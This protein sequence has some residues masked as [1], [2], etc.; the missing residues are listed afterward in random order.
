MSEPLCLLAEVPV[1]A[2]RPYAS[3]EYQD[4][5]PVPTPASVYGMLLSLLGVP[6]ERKAEHCGAELALAVER[7]PERSKVFRKLRRGGDLE[8][9]RPD[10]QDVLTDL[11]LWVWVRRGA[12]T[13][14][15]CLADRLRAALANRFADVTRSGGVS[16]GESSYLLNAL[17]EQ[18]PPNEL[19]FVVPDATGFYSLPVWVDH[20]VAANTQ[21]KRFRIDDE[22]RATTDA[23]A[24]AWF[25]IPTPPAE[26]A[27]V[28]KPRRGRKA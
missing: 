15:P 18:R 1:C 27:P 28:T 16:L 21:L 25:A 22:P 20:R 9:I 24:E 12:E 2:F 4:T 6:R 8:N 3:R 23:L 5:Y 10:Y 14:E 26:P 11:R 19:V 7:V 13:A 17:S